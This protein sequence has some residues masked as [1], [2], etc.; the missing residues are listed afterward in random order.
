MKV[1]TLF[2]LRW[3][4]FIRYP[5]IVQTIM[6]RL[7]IGGLVLSILAFL[8]FLGMFV[9]QWTTL[10]FSN[11]TNVLIIFLLSTL[12]LLFLDFILKFLFKKSKFDFANF[13]RFPDSNQSIFIYSII[14]E[15]FSFWNW[16]LLCFFFVYL[17]RIIYPHYGSW[18]TISFFS[19]C[20]FCKLQLVLGSI[21]SN[22]TS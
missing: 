4:S 9:E 20:V 10:L 18:I 7:L 13:R 1:L 6:L 22:Q 15:I 12:A 16:S 21:V 2:L 5:L 17:T 19:F 11:E 3:K 8:C 14:R